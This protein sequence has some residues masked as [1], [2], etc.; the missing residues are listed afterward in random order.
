MSDV[1]RKRDDV[2]SLKNGFIVSLHYPHTI[3]TLSE[4]YPNDSEGVC[5]DLLDYSLFQILCEVGADLCGSPFRGDL[6]NVMLYH[7]LDELLEG[8]LIGVPT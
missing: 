3:P 1:R 4:H 7:E 2:L 6:G 5:S 8:C